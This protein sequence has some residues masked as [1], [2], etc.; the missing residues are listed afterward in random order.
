MFVI[1]SG[2]R[3]LKV[4]VAVR[5]CSQVGC[6]K[7][8]SE[9]SLCD[10]LRNVAKMLQVATTCKLLKTKP[11]S[12]ATGIYISSSLRQKSLPTNAMTCNIEPESALLPGLPD[13]VAKH[14]L[15][16]VPRIYFQSLGFVCK[17]WRKFIQSKEFYVVRKT[18]RY[19]GRM[20]LC[21]DN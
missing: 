6:Q 1:N 8:S 17:L 3:N 15:A 16:L 5:T 2:S 7:H 10:E 11:K 12:H 18:G 19:R 9:W 4:H 13:D 14:C 20:D 21:T